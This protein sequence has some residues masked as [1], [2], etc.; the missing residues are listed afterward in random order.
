MVGHQTVY[1]GVDNSALLYRCADRPRV[2]G[3]P[4]CI[5]DFV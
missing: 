2:G 4:L 3:E 5:E 1:D